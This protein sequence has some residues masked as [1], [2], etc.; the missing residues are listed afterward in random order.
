MNIIIKIDYLQLLLTK[1]DIIDNS[2]F[3]ANYLLF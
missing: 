1:I 2:I 3:P